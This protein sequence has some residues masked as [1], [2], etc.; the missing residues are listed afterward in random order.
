MN[1]V[2][3][4]YISEYYDMG[5][6]TNLQEANALFLKD[7]AIEGLCKRGITPEKPEQWKEY[8]D[9]IDYEVKIINSG[10]LADFFLNTAFGCLKQ[11]SNGI[12]LGLG[13]GSA[14]G[15]LVAYCLR[16]TEIDP[17]FFGLP[18]ERFL[19]P[20]RVNSINS[21]DIDIDIPRTERKRILEIYKDDFGRDRTYQVINKLKWTKKTAIDD[22]GRI[23]GISFAMRKKISKLI[24][25]TEDPESIPEVVDYL[26]AHPVIRDNYQQLAG[27][28]KS[29]GVHA[30]G[31]IILDKPIEYRASILRING[32]DCID[33][34]GRTCDSLGFLKQ[35]LLGINTLTIVSDCLDLLLNQVTLPSPYE[36]N[37]PKVFETINKSTLGLFQI[38]APGANQVCQELQPS[39][40]DELS[41]LLAICRPGAVDSGDKDH[42]VNRKHGVEEIEY[43]HPLLE[44]ILKDTY[45]CIVYQEDAMNIVS[46]FAG[47]S[48]VDADLIRKGI[49]KKI[50]SIFDEYYPKFIQACVQRDIPQDVAELVWSKMEASASYSFNKSHAVSYAALTYITAWLKTYYPVEFL[51][52]VLNNTDKEDKKQKIY[53]ELRSLG[54]VIKNPDINKSKAITSEDENNIYLSF[55]LIK[56]IGESA[57]KKIVDHQP[58][59]SFDDF[60]ERAG[61]NKSVK[62]ALI[63]C[64][65]FDCFQSNR[66]A[67]Y[68]KVVGNSLPR[69]AIKPFDPNFD[70]DDFYAAKFI[71]YLCEKGYI[72]FDDVW[73]EKETLFREFER[74]KIN[75]N[76]NLLDLYDLE[77]I[78][79]ELPLSNIKALKSNKEDYRDYYI[80]GIVSEY[81]NHKDYAYLT[82][83]DGFDVIS[84]FVDPNFISRYVDAFEVGTPLLMHVNGK[85]NKYS[86]LSLINLKYPKK[87]NHEYNLYNGE[88][89][90]IL[91][92]LQ[93]SN[94]IPCG[95]ASNVKYFTS[96]KGNPCVR[97]DLRLNEETLLEGRIQAGAPPLMVEGSFVFF[98]I[99]D[100]ETFLNILEV[101]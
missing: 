3:I 78:D 17:I 13:R 65:A 66:C 25:E 54:K 72:E 91:Q 19:N 58:Y 67:L 10:N 46:Q 28:L 26:N 60:C 59:A 64:G 88:A 96:K 41:A 81:K 8:T 40:F 43:D 30:G 11:K 51:L 24:G 63:E 71:N 101:H 36:F 79:I 93:K 52:A 82:I 94:S 86:L 2:D 15:S 27:M 55:N 97:Y 45:G 37:D 39:N 75:P 44:P 12:L 92:N 35:D 20:T 87:Y 84:L 50:Q 95:V 74:I 80:K 33:A 48:M 89:M 61:V 70:W 34:D 1:P 16:I 21:A 77:D 98:I 83:S 68:V 57:I 56:G 99:E 62:I 42:Y 9:R 32:V 5:L 23:I 47:M 7:L 53:N 100:N 90:Q 76:G 29:Y 85:G 38:E 18:F 73:T 14:A 49:G 22:L 4:D 31:L 69:N 6:A